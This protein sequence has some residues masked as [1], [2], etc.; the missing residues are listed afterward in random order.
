MVR[1]GAPFGGLR[2]SP[3]RYCRHEQA[4]GDHVRRPD[5]VR[6]RLEA[7][8][9]RRMKSW[10]CRGM[11]RPPRCEGACA[12]RRTPG[13]CYRGSRH[14]RRS[15]RCH[16]THRSGMRAGPSRGEPGLRTQSDQRRD[17]EPNAHRRPR[18]PRGGRAAG[19]RRMKS[20]GHQMRFSGLR[21]GRHGRPGPHRQRMA[22]R[23]RN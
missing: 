6:R 11:V 13:S 4:P 14:R 18:G 10:S 9:T 8:A 19:R 20:S 5:H 2:N 23:V 1:L 22:C 21:H 15:G 7:H 3:K 16:G 17:E 12:D